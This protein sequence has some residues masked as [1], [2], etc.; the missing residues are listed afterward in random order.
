MQVTVHHCGAVVSSP[1]FDDPLFHDQMSAQE[2][3]L[4]HGFVS[5]EN[6]DYHRWLFPTTEI[7]E[8]FG[9]HWSGEW[10]VGCDLIFHNIARA[11]EHGTAKPLTRKGW[12]AYLH[13]T[14]HGARRLTTVLSSMH[15]ARVDELLTAFPE[16]WHGKCIAD[17]SIPM[18]FDSLS[19][20]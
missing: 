5:A 13:S 9:N 14:N 18:R 6:L 15:F 10:T 3:N 4:V 2:E 7:M 19:G 12:K 1:F 11:L 8:D 16:S 17:I 20:N